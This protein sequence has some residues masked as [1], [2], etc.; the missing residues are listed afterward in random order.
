MKTRNGLFADV[1]ENLWNDW[2]WQVANRAETVEDLK[3]YMNLTPDEEEGVRK[4]LG[5]LRMAVTPYYL[6]LIDLDDPFDPIRKMAIP[7]AEELEYADLLLHV[8]DASNPEWRDQTAVVED[9]IRELGAGELPRIDVLNKS[10]RQT[11]GEIMPH[12]QDICSL[13]AKTGEGVDKLLEM[14]GERLDSGSRRCVLHIPY[15]KG[16]LLDQLYRE[17]KVENVEYG[18]TIA[19]T[20][21]CTPKVLGQMAP[22]LVE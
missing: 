17:A 5:K 12:G 2:H 9:L 4:T 20:A 19:V 16:G 3:K 21:V 1:P 18:E 11:A 10:D 8:I 15:D 6:S 14:I 13:S 22:F 7:R